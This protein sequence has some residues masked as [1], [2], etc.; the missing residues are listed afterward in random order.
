MLPPQHNPCA[1]DKSSVTV[2]KHVTPHADIDV[3]P[4]TFHAY[5]RG[6]RARNTADKY[7]SC[8]AAFLRLMDA[9]GY[10]TFSEIPSGLLSEYASLLSREGATP[11]TVRVN[12]YGVKKY[13]EWVQGKGVAVPTQTKTQLPK[14]NLQ[15]RSVL[16]VE[17]ISE[18]FRLADTELEEPVRTA[19]M[20]LPCCGLRASEIVSLRLGH[21]HRA[22]IKLSKLKRGKPTFKE[23]LYLK[24]IGKGGRERHV[25][26]MDEGVEILLGYLA[27]WRSRQKGPWLFPRKHGKKHISDRFLR[28]AVSIVRTRMGIDLT[29]HTLR[30]TYITMLWRKG[31]DLKTLATI[32]GHANVQTTVD[33]YIAMEPADAI[34]AMH[35]AGSSLTEG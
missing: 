20:M 27:G 10:R 29:P 9:N 19:V 26:L 21:I 22:N 3:T 6:L 11:S 17:R 24:T 2:S 32:A 30:R 15:M 35:N 7:A 23:T 4:K 18:Y 5:L 34:R 16:P 8:A 13:L 28:D 12:V 25:P 14:R 33:H 1:S 31:V